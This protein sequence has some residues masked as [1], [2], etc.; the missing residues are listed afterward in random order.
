[1]TT[2]IF[3]FIRATGSQ[4]ISETRRPIGPGFVAAILIG[5]MGMT[6][7][8]DNKST[9]SSL[10]DERKQSSTSVSETSQQQ[11][12][13]A[14]LLATLQNNFDLAI[15]G[16]PK[17]HSRLA[18]MPVNRSAGIVCSPARINRNSP[19]LRIVLPPHNENRDG[20]LAAIVPDGSLRIIYVA[21]GSD[22][23]TV[24]II[25]PSNAIDWESARKFNTFDVDAR[26][27]D[28][29]VPGAGEPSPL[30][31]EAGVYQLALMDSFP[32]E[33]PTR[34]EGPYTIRTGCVLHWNP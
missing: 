18:E 34:G 23:E 15:R 29:L 17:A 9:K 24:D 10:V 20:V 32:Y 11:P 26:S 3:N 12:P 33:I 8:C 6:V 25:I 2:F 5:L 27:F 28:A 21:Y 7:A 22:V 14:A 4:R 16:A 30:F 31:Q 1:M 19:F 13:S